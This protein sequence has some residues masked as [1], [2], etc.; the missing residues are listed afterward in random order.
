MSIHF[1]IIVVSFNPGDR[2][3]STLDSIYT[4]DYWD[5][6]VIIKDAGSD[7]GSLTSLQASGYFDKQFVK[8]RSSV[9]SLPDN[10][11]YDGMNRALE[12]IDRTE[13]TDREDYVIF[14][15]CGD[16]FYDKQT[17]GKVADFIDGYISGGKDTSRMKIF[18]GDQY[19][20]STSSVVS[21]APKINEFALFRNVPCHQVCFYDAGLFADRA[22][23]TGYRVRA[24]Y[25]HFL[26]CIYKKNAVAVHMKDIISRYEGGGYSESKEGKAISAKEHREI[27]DR[28]MGKKA[29]GYRMIM[30]L[31]GAG[32]RTRL[33]EDPKYSGL[34][35]KIKSFIYKN[36]R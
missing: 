34:Y 8:E 10:G 19:N 5:Y 15:N 12:Y 21:S 24:D 17:L 11:I 31:S 33:A 4:Q 3:K 36:R 35:N 26:Y 7:D 13:S 6:D 28:Y 20:D 2:L 16:R 29:A 14:L 23:D 9:Y 18:Y 30:R 1:Y 22:Y 27:T 25:E 32:L